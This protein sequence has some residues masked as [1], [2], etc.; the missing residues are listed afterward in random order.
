MLI[1]LLPG[2]K[3]EDVPLLSHPGE[4]FVYVL[5]GILTYFI[6]GKTETLY[7]GDS[8]HGFGKAPHNFANLS[9]NNVK[10]LYVVTPPIKQ[11]HRDL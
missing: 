9:N 1:T 5:E 6:D 7:P 11:Q 3:K 10:V 4:D 8:Y 2:Q